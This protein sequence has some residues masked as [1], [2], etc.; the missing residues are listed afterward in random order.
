MAN[1]ENVHAVAVVL[2]VPPAAAMVPREMDD[3]DEMDLAALKMAR[4]WKE[5]WRTRCVYPVWTWAV[6]R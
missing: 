4:A 3:E 5:G 6:W 1:I 2:W